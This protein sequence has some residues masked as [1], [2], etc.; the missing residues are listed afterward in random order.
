[1]EGTLKAQEKAAEM[2]ESFN[3]WLWKDPERNSRLV[4]I[5]NDAHNNTRPR[6]FDGSHQ[7]FPGMAPHWQEQMREH[8]RDA[9]FRVGHDGTALLAHE[10]GFGKTAVMVASAMERKRLGLIDKPTFVVP[11]ATHRQFV[12]DFRKIYPGAKLLSPEDKEFNAD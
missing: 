10:V 3:D 4:R 1:M 2:Q 9:I 5:Y 7:T 12:A 6:V 11:K 8:Q